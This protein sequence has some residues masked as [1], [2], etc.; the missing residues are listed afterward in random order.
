MSLT[1]EEGITDTFYELEIP[2][3]IVVD[4]TFVLVAVYPECESEPALTA[5][6]E[7]FIYLTNQSVNEQSLLN[8]Q[9]YPNPTTGQLT[10]EMEGLTEVEVYNLVGQCLLRQVVSEGTAI[11]DMSALQNGVYMVKV[12][13]NSGTVMQKVV[14]M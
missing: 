13:A 6:G 10:V 4:Y 1:P 8:A 7:N 5:N 9:L 3:D 2:V 11:I 12:S 14:I